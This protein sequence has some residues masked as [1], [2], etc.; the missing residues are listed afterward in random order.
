MQSQE[1]ADIERENLL[2]GY[3]K[4]KEN[5]VKDI[6]IKLEKILDKLRFFSSQLE[7]LFKKILPGDKVCYAYLYLL[8][9]ILMFRLFNLSWEL[10]KKRIH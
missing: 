9:K 3:E 1:T 2:K 5:I 8:S 10:T 7:K 6:M 4:L